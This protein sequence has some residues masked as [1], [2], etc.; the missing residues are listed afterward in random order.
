M[1]LFG[2]SSSAL[3]SLF[4]SSIHLRFAFESTYRFGFLS[5][6]GLGILLLVL[7]LRLLLCSCWYFVHPPAP[8][9]YA[10]LLIGLLFLGSISS[11]HGI[12]SIHLPLSL[13]FVSTPHGISFTCASLFLRRSTYRFGL[14]SHSSFDLPLL[15]STFILH[16]PTVS[17]HK[18]QIWVPAFKLHGLN[19]SSLP[20]ILHSPTIPLRFWSKSGFLH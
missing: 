4:P 17:G 15:H 8:S 9:T 6:G 7:W 1:F 10:S 12:S 11:P 14:H 2:I 13:G 18:T 19:H 3:T 5:F 16:S 20:F